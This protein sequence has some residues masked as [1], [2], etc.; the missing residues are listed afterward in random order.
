MNFSYQARGGELVINSST[1]LNQDKS[2]FLIAKAGIAYRAM[3]FDRDTL[4]NITKTDGEA[5]VGFSYKLPSAIK[6]NL[7]YAR[8]LWREPQ[9][10]RINPATTS[11]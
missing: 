10:N 9:N 1:S 4:R 5:Q 11:R 8:Y 3:H 6:F 2:L 7:L